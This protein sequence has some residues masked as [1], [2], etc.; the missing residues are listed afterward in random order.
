MVFTPQFKLDL[1]TASSQAF[2]QLL[3]DFE[4][5]RAAQPQ[6]PLHFKNG[7]VTIDQ[8][9]AESLLLRNPVGANRKPALPTVKYYARQML[10]K[11]WKKTGQPVLL[12][13]KGTLL[14]SSHRLW[15]CYLSGAPF[16]TYIVTDVPD[17]PSLFAYIDA[18]KGRS[19]ADALATA[20]LNGIARQMS[21]VVSMAMQYEYECYTPTTRKPMEKTA[22]IEVVTYVQEHPNLK[23]GTR[24][25]NGEYVAAATVI[26]HK[27]VAGFTAYQIL[28]LHGEDVLDHFMTL[29]GTAPDDPV[30][31]DPLEALRKVLDDDAHSVAPM[32]KHQVL[33]HVIKAFNAWMRNEKVKRIQLRVNEAFPRFVAAAPLQQAAE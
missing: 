11:T 7:W 23:M 9:A 29:L 26:A 27:D 33:G 6:R 16:D 30:E 17:E 24:L 3:D 10:A 14:D 12:T 28:E 21:G 5:W 32:K 8:E 4:P 20:G 22:P 18:G 15:A 1:T 25:M 31:G 2:T 13:E 19:A